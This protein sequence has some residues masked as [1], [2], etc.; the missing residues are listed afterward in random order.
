[1]NHKHIAFAFGTLIF[2]AA[3]AGAY[4]A[5]LVPSSRLIQCEELADILRSPNAA[6]PLILHVGPH[7]L[8]SQAHIPGAEHMNPPF[9][10]SSLQQLRKRVE[11]LPR[12]T[13]IVIYCGCCP[14]DRCPNV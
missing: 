13:F 14:W 9:T 5:S 3:S 7:V 4:Q 2:M 10:D 11:K 1:M 8:Y 12:N 6:K